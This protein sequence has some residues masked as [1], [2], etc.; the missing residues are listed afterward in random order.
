MAGGVS[1]ERRNMKI[2]IN[3]GHTE[4]G[5]GA[6]AIG[7]FSES[8]HTRII[9]KALMK[10]F[11]EGGDEVYDCTVDF[12][13]MQRDY[14][15]E[16]VELANRQYLDW[17]ISIHFNASPE[18]KGYGTEVFTYNG[19]KHPEALAICK[20]MEDLGF[21]NRGVKDGSKLYVVRN[22]KAKAMLI[23][24]CFCDNQGDVEIYNLNN[25]DK[26]V[27]A[28]YRA[29][30]KEVKKESGVENHNMGREEFIEFVG[31]IAQRD[32]VERG[33]VLPSI[34]V[35]QAMKESAFGKSE[36]AQN[37][38]AL[39]GIKKNGWTGRTYVK[40]ATEQN[41]DGSYRVD[42]NAEWRAY[43]SWEQSIIDH[44][45]YLATRRVGNQR[46]PNWNKLIGVTDYVLAVQYLQGAEFPYA[47]SQSYEESIIENYI[48]PYNLIR[49]DSKEED[50]FAPEGSLYVVQLGAYRSK[51]NAER[52]IKQL[53]AMGVRSMLKLYKVEE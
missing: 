32:W 34:V 27:D 40:D 10:R 5:A 39:F 35:A 18:H 48:E 4:K 9:G 6:G 19:R 50:V 49:F 47:T 36:L 45:T 53:E 29:V 12:A 15:R 16:T 42:K 23:E 26:I 20:N 38:N 17:F 43:D 24:V 31:A 25:T 44:N 7:I 37:A 52:F 33:L 2:G 28:I 3:C 22:T 51:A 11:I 41:T 21:R 13:E 14:L 30:H 8:I 1:E 46:I